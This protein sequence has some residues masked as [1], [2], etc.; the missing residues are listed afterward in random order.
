MK[1]PIRLE[2]IEIKEIDLGERARVDYERIEE[3]AESINKNGLVQP[4]AVLDK[5]AVTTWDTNNVVQLHKDRKYLLLAGGR[6]HLAFTEH[7][8]SEKIPA[9]IYDKV[10]TADEIKEI[11]LVENIDRLDLTWHERVKLEKQLHDLQVKIKGKRVSGSRSD[12]GHTL[13]DTGKMLGKSKF[14]VSK[15]IKLAEAME[16]LPEL[17]KAK[18]KRDAEKMLQRLGKIHTTKQRATELTKKRGNT[19][20]DLQHGKL[21][22]SYIVGDFFD[23]IKEVPDASVSFVELDPPYGIKLHQEKKGGK[24]NS[25]TYNEILGSEYPEF[26]RGIFRECFRV[27]KPDSWIVTWF[28]P[29]PWFSLISEWMRDAGFHTRAIPGIWSK[30]RGQTQ[31]PYKYLANA[32]EMFFYGSKG[33]PRIA[34]PG[35]VN[36]YSYPPVDANKKIHITERPIEMIQDVITTFTEGDGMALVPFLGSGNSLLALSNIGMK[37]FGY[38]I[39]PE[40]K[41]SYVL[42]V[43][44]GQPGHYAS[45]SPPVK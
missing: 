12:E 15:D 29:D 9:R 4:I 43:K 40:H 13:E 14:S 2:E 36:T 25:I 16:K 11:E 5:S 42:R 18:T 17:S 38:D 10:L 44:Q 7:K 21:I 26:M 27:M 6:R 22:E 30:G 28:G 34:K 37:G 20:L 24:H 31:Q 33:N 8:I 41:D 3:L 39:S 23:H 32:Y 45:Y 19:P 35:R 1:K